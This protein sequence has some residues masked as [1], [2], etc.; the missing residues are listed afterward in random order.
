MISEK[1]QTQAI[2]AWD[3]EKHKPIALHGLAVPHNKTAPAMQVFLKSF[4]QPETSKLID[5]YFFF[6]ID[7]YFF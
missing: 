5:V 3:S 1:R 6:I 4:G 2:V 7:L